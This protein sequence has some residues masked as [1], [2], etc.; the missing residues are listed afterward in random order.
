MD[1]KMISKIAGDVKKNSLSLASLNGISSAVSRVIVPAVKNETLKTKLEKTTARCDKMAVVY[2]GIT[3][4]SALAQFILDRLPE[5]DDDLLDDFMDEDMDYPDDDMDDDF[6]DDDPG[7]DDTDFGTGD[8]NA[9]AP[10]EGGDETTT[11]DAGEDDDEDDSF[12][13]VNV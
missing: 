12:V 1:K 9:D 5:R 7:M 8:A 10:E 2:L 6:M 13:T 4:V 11:D 3:G